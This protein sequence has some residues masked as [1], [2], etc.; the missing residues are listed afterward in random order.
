MVEKRLNKIINQCQLNWCIID[1]V[2]NLSVNFLTNTVQEENINILINE[3]NTEYT[4][5]FLS[6]AKS[7]SKRVEDSPSGMANEANNLM[8]RVKERLAE[9]KQ[10]KLNELASK[11]NLL[12]G[13]NELEKC[14]EQLQ[15]VF[16]NCEFDISEDEDKCESLDLNEAQG[17]EFN[18]IMEERRE[19][20]SR[21][22]VII[23]NTVNYL[24]NE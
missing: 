13:S 15:T 1:C 17:E 10:L 20:L 19:I 24:N 5:K 14:L 3:I 22:E 11:F 9:M 2:E 6:S 8:Q 16:N 4:P 12:K 23:E 7:K 18:N 21:I